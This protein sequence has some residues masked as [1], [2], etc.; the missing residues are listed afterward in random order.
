MFFRNQIHA[1]LILILSFR[2][3]QGPFL[4]LQSHLLGLSSINLSLKTVRAATA[5]VAAQSGGVACAQHVL[6]AAALRSLQATA[7]ALAKSRKRVS[8]TSSGNQA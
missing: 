8:C 2:D 7:D 5:F 6:P 4:L 1:L 3:S